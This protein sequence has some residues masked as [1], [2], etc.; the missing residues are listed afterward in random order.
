MKWSVKRFEQL[1]L[2]ELYQILKKRVEVFVVEQE[3]AY[4]EIDGND[5]DCYHLFLQEG[6]TIVAYARLIPRGVLYAEPSIGRIMVDNRYRKDGYGR[7]LVKKA[8][9]IIYDDWQEELIKIHAQVYLLDF[10]QS[11]GFKEVTAHYLED[12]IPHVDMVLEK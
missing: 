11:F 2:A 10:Y 8:I 7:K 12:N 1:S 4:P 3:C 9:E 5:P 6:E